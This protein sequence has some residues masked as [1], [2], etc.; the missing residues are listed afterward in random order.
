[1]EQI[2]RMR[3]LLYEFRKTYREHPELGEIINLFKRM[4]IEP[5][6]KIP[7]AR[8][9]LDEN[10][11]HIEVS[12]IFFN[13]YIKTPDDIGFVICHEILHFVLGHL[14]FEGRS[15]VKYAGHM[16]ANLAM[17]IVINQKLYKFFKKP[18]TLFMQKF[19]QNS[20][21]PVEFLKP[22]SAIDKKVFKHKVCKN[23]YL[24]ISQNSELSLDVVLSHVKFHSQVVYIR[25]CEIDEKIPSGV[26]KKLERLVKK[27][28]YRAHGA[29]HELEK[30]TVEK[31][32]Y[33]DRGGILRKIRQMLTEGSDS[34]LNLPFRSNGVLPFFGRSDFLFLPVGVYIPLFHENPVVE[35]TEIGVRI[36]VDV[37]GS[38]FEELPFILA[39]IEELKDI[40]AFPLY[41]LSTVVRPITRE[42]LLKRSIFT[43]K[44]TDYNAFARHLL[45]NRFKKAVFITDGYSE[46]DPYLSAQ[47]RVKSHILTVLT[48][49][50]DKI[51][52]RFSR[53][54][55]VLNGIADSF[56]L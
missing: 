27:F 48:T 24:T 21:C 2:E 52:K 17:D 47:L 50:N 1:M 3:K 39:L 14:T 7:T 43:T 5:N 46:I 38:I 11:L 29:G 6:N 28:G 22:I 30:E 25:I 45:D 37:S 12:P 42:E 10:L 32:K 13:N 34:R 31:K 26:L 35:P 36:Y 54:V 55:M 9:S 44:G 53:D 4:T 18:E 33:I 23:F 16:Q 40:I 41:C 20:S 49:K 8:I 15:A 56:L 19:Y 51:V